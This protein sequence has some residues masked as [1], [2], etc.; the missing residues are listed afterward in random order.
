MLQSQPLVLFLFRLS[1]WLGF[2]RL[3]FTQCPEGYKNSCKTPYSTFSKHC[4]N[5]KLYL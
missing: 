1:L 3:Y 5:V 2:A 4:S